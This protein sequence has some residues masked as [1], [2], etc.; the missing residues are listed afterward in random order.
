MPS[1]GPAHRR[2]PPTGVVMVFSTS[3][4]GAYFKLTEGGPSNSSHV[5]L[6]APVSMEPA[7]TNVGLAWLA[8]GS[9]CLFIAG[10]WGA[11]G[12]LR[13]PPCRCQI[14]VAPWSPGLLCLTPGFTALTMCRAPAQPRSAPLTSPHKHPPSRPVPVLFCRASP[15]ASEVRGVT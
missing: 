5:D 4:F 1:H 6:P 11:E 10:E 15:D 3:A 8:V 13:G 7:D 9:M 12:R 14:P 2:P